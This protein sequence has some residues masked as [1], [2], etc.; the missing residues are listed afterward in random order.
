MTAWLS[1]N[2]H[3]FYYLHDLG[4][5]CQYSISQTLGPHMKRLTC[6]R[7]VSGYLNYAKRG[8]FT[9]NLGPVIR[10]ESDHYQSSV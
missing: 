5:L 10:V 2:S 3:R 7:T 9:W 1:G 8:V 6:Q 4:I